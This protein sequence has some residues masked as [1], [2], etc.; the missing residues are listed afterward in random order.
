MAWVYAAS[1]DWAAAAREVEAAEAIDARSSAT[2]N[3]RGNLE[4]Q[5]GHWQQAILAVRGSLELDPLDVG[6][7]NLLAGA[8]SADGQHREAA[9]ALRRALELAPLVPSARALL[10]TELLLDGHSE[11]ALSEAK[12]ETSEEERDQVL[13]MAYYALGR[14]AES[15]RLLA[16]YEEKYAAAYAGD[17]AYVHAFRGERD[18]AFQWL[19]RALLQHDRDLSWIKGNIGALPG[20]KDDPRYVAI[21]HKLGLPE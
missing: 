15:D 16:T 19:D 7:L 20:I 13:V 21:L 1:L 4:F 3:A 18:L 6:N 2:L 9:Q 17:I 11:Q 12:L 14:R 5:L 8:L 10:A